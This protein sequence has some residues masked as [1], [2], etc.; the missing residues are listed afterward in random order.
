MR[1]KHYFHFL[2]LVL[3]SSSGV[4]LSQLAF[5]APNLDVIPAPVPVIE[6]NVP[7]STNQEVHIQ[8]LQ[9]T[10]IKNDKA[11]SELKPT[12]W[13]AESLGSTF[14]AVGILSGVVNKNKSTEDLTVVEI[15]RTQY[16]LDSTAQEFGVE[17][18]SNDYLGVSLGYK[19]LPDWNTNLVPFYK[20][21]VRAIYS[22]RDQLANLID[23]Q[24]YYAT[25]SFGLENL[26]RSHKRIQTE[27][28]AGVGSLGFYYFIQIRYAI[29]D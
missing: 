28:G 17:F 9:P 2:T 1:L 22:P 26:F 15:G 23:Y 13:S 18:Y 6:K 25:G 19:W 4:L 8:S 27:A 29:F 16:N 24:R 7:S 12:R 20:A 10:L 5:S 21:G 14:G 3:I 11:E